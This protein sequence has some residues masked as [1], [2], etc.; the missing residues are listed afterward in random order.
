MMKDKQIKPRPK[1]DMDSAYQAAAAALSMI[2]STRE[3]FVIRQ[4]NIRGGKFDFDYC[5]PVETDDDEKREIMAYLCEIVGTIAGHAL[6]CG[7]ILSAESLGI[8]DVEFREH[9]DY[10]AKV[11]LGFCQN[12]YSGCIQEMAKSMSHCGRLFGHQIENIFLKHFHGKVEER[13]VEYR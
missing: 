11:L 7:E 9:L 2:I 10:Q 12:E 1:Y 3:T 5:F 6:Y 13:E 8:E 4:F